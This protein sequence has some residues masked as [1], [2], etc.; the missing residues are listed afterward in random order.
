MSHAGSL[1]NLIALYKSLGGG[2]EQMEN[3]EGTPKL[4]PSTVPIVHSPTP[5][6]PK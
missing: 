1:T 2:W 5:S 4:V 3:P 6:W